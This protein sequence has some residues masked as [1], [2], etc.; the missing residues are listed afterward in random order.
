MNQLNA[1]RATSITATKVNI[2][3][4]F[5]RR[6]A[7]SN[8]TIAPATTPVF[9]YKK[10]TSC[11]AFHSFVPSSPSATNAGRP[12]STN[13]F[14]LPQ[15]NFLYTP[16]SS[17]ELARL[18][19]S[20]AARFI[21][22]APRTRAERDAVDWQRVLDEVVVLQALAVR[23]GRS[24]TA[25]ELTDA[26]WGDAPPASAHKNLQSCIVRLRKVLG[27]DGLDALPAPN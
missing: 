26:L 13:A 10:G 11:T 2:R 24:V 7:Q 12:A 25:D 27:A 22:S 21:A 6:Y 4:A 19:N 23:Q 1:I 15:E 8:T 16:M 20:F 3:W 9:R 5:Q 14:T 18:A 17:A